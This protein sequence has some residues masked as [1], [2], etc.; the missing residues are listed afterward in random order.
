M[1]LL[2]V[3]PGEEEVSEIIPDP[4]GSAETAVE[5]FGVK[6]GAS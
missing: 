1:T 3:E 5:G 6:A 4:T 2:A